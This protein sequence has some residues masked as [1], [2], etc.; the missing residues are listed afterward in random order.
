MV[1]GRDYDDAPFNL[2]TQG[3]RQPG[4]SIKPF[5][6]AE[7]LQQGIG[8]GSV[9]PSRKRVFTVPGHQ[10]ARRSSSST[11]S[12]DKYAGQPDARRRADVLR[13]LRLRGGGH[14]GRDQEDR[15]GWPSA[16]ASARRSRRTRD[17]ARRPQAGRD[18]ARHG[19]RLRDVRDGRP[20]H[21]RHAGRE[22]RRA[23]RHPARSTAPSGEDASSENDLTTQARPRPRHRRRDRR[24]HDHAS[25]RRA[26]AERA[27]LGRAVRGGQDRHDREQRR[28]VV[29]RL[30]RRAGPSRSGSAI[31]TSSSRC[32]PSSPGAPVEGGTYP[33]ADLARLHGRAPTPSSTTA[34]PRSA[35]ARACRRKP[36][37][38]PDARPRRPR[39]RSSRPSRRPC[40]RA[41]PTRAG[42]ADADDPVAAARD[43]RRHRRRRRLHAAPATTH[44]RRRRR[45]PPSRPPAPPAPAPAA[46]A[47]AA[48]PARP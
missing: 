21:R 37:A 31:P 11:T 14:P 46:R 28:R 41:A 16:W 45:R 39:R 25:S 24:D 8:P 7:A 3:Q 42:A 6:L 47:P 20:A 38:R 23:R 4:S 48:A 27:A 1:G 33:G 9:W 12:R 44:R 34:T 19:P 26:P 22:R 32:S 13:Q 36:P 2:A 40:P 10:A 30:H 18:A 35:R 43:R 29:R 5:I 15:R 17:D